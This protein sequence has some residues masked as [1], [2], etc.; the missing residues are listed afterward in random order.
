MILMLKSIS[1]E[2]GMIMN[3][4]ALELK[5]MQGNYAGDC[6]DAEI[7]AFDKCLAGHPIHWVPLVRQNVFL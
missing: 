5:Q 6:E 4:Y 7:T 3:D 2:I 1:N